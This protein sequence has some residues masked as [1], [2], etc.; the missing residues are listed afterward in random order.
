MDCDL[1]SYILPLM[2]PTVFLE[3]CSS[4]TTYKVAGDQLEMVTYDSHRAKKGVILF[5]HPLEIVV[6]RFNDVAGPDKHNRV[7]FHDWCGTYDCFGLTKMLV[8]NW[9][10]EEQRELAEKLPCHEEFYRIIMWYNQVFKMLVGNVKEELVLHFNAFDGNHGDATV[11]KLFDFLGL[12]KIEG[13]E[14]PFQR[15]ES[16][17]YNWRN[18]LNAEEMYYLWAFVEATGIPKTRL[19]FHRYFRHIDTIN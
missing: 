11:T 14:I 8:D 3:S 6:S 16:D 17:F 19:Q 4:G 2:K 9:Y 10:T 1:E 18:W 13:Y 15:A 7:A 12:E 5:R